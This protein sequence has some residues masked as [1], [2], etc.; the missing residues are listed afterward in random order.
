MVFKNTPAELCLPDT[1]LGNN[2]YVFNSGLSPSKKTSIIA[3][4]SDLSSDDSTTPA[5]A[6]KQIERSLVKSGDIGFA[7]GE[8]YECLMHSSKFV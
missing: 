5:T 3:N 4:V 6:R 7:A 2:G 1:D 8:V